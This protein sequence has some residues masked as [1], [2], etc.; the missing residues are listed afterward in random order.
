MLE[1]KR[2][3]C[4]AACNQHTFGKI[5]LISVCA[6]AH[7]VSKS[8]AFSC[9]VLHPFSLLNNT[10]KSK[11]QKDKVLQPFSQPHVALSR[12]PGPSNFPAA[13]PVKKQGPVV[14]FKEGPELGKELVLH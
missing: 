2:V 7:S 1:I 13:L 12:I 5:S 4:D 8:P 14:C 11:G 6:L 9:F 3:P 10:T